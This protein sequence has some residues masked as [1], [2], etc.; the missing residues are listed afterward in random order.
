MK[1]F[2]TKT[3]N[4]RE[5]CRVNRITNKIFKYKINTVTVQTIPEILTGIIFRSDYELDDREDMEDE[6]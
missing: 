5:E 3:E 6:M 1:E 4:Q 2:K